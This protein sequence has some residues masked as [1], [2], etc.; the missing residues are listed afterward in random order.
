MDD[1][2]LR[3]EDLMAMDSAAL[4]A[5]MDR[6]HA[7]DPDQL[8]GTMYVGVDLS[9]PEAGRRVL[10]H[11]FRKTFHRD[12]PGGPVRGWNI[13][14]KQG[15]DRSV[16][17]VR[18]HREPLRDR[19]GKPVDFGHY[20]VKPAAGIDWPKGWRG[21][22]FLDYGA[23]RNKALDPARLGYTPLVAVN[24]GDMSL[25]LGWEI[26]KTPLGFAALPLYWALELEGELD[27]VVAPPR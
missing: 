2:K 17:A 7:L 3:L 13:K 11:S 8:A 26:F 19:R 5:V 25:L 15:R 22:H 14:I 12:E 23:G 4:Q 16:E 10:W 9:M 21:G 24:E 1:K 20:V 6:G 18:T 27:A